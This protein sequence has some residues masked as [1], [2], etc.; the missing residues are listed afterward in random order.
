MD[1]E[2]DARENLLGYIRV[3]GIPRLVVL[4]GKTGRILVDNC[5]GQP[6]DVNTWRRI[7]K[8]EKVHSGGGCGGTEGCC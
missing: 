3:K 8:G 4:D 2:D 1:F 5:V 6:L 7:A